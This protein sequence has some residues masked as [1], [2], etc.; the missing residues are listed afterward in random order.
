MNILVKFI[1][2]A[3]LTIPSASYSF[4]ITAFPKLMGA[5]PALTR[6]DKIQTWTPKTMFEHVNGEAELLKRYGAVSL[7]FVSYENGSGDYV[8]VDILD[9]GRPINAYGLYRLYAGCDG[10]EY[11]ISDATVLADEYSPYALLGQYFLKINIDISSNADRGSVLVNDFL[12]H[13]SNHLPEQS[14]VPSTLKFLKMNARTPCEVNYHPEHIDYDLESGPGY[15]WV[16][17]D[18]N[19][20]FVTILDSQDNAE[21]YS[22]SMKDKGT[23]SVLFWQNVVI[24]QKTEEDGSTDYMKEIIKGFDKK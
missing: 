12:V 23:V 19:T 11:N 16:G 18:G 15:S 9:L 2:F 17:R 6:I 5:D 21:N 22:K 24:W 20:Y 14:A 10:Q 7:T 1:L 3:I 4:N 13:F 8:S